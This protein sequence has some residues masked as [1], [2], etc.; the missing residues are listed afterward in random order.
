MHTSQSVLYFPI[1]CT[2]SSHNTQSACTPAQ[3]P[4]LTHMHMYAHTRAH[5]PGPHL[6]CL[7]H[8]DVPTQALT[9][10][11]HAT[12]RQA[13]SCHFNGCRELGSV[14]AAGRLCLPAFAKQFPWRHILALTETDVCGEEGPTEGARWEVSMSSAPGTNRGCLTSGLGVYLT[15]GVLSCLTQ[16]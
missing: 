2:P 15:K 6:T 16:E 11:T 13:R 1:L 7:M 5:D 14:S 12:H 9:H 3:F 8:A 4:L 10:R